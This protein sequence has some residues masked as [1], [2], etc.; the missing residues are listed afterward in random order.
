MKDNGSNIL[1]LWT[2]QRG[3]DNERIMPHKTQTLDC[4]PL[5][6]M[7]LTRKKLHTSFRE[8]ECEGRAMTD[9]CAPFV[10]LPGRFQVGV[11]VPDLETLLS[12]EI[13]DV[14]PYKVGWPVNLACDTGKGLHTCFAVP[15]FFS[16][17]VW[18]TGACKSR[19]RVV[20]ARA[21]L[22][23]QLGA[24]V[25]Q[26][27][28]SPSSD[29]S[30]SDSQLIPGSC[31]WYFLFCFSDRKESPVARQISASSSNFWVP[32]RGPHRSSAPVCIQLLRICYRC[33]SRWIRWT[34]SSPL[35]Q[36]IRCK[37]GYPCKS[38]QT[39]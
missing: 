33:C 26:Y 18:N 6:T 28:I 4:K 29:P 35:R 36:R 38:V 15:C 3:Q 12:W 14:H 1:F 10:S 19:T 25:A 21:L 16:S 9:I 23:P 8:K 11:V 22:C 20:V 24:G 39:N 37:P 13:Q 30:V 27:M 34:T 2:V 5:Q 7:S 32:D 17:I 31:I